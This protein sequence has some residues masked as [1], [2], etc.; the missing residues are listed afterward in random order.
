MP[1]NWSFNP[2]DVLGFVGG[3]INTYQT[4]KTNER[5]TRETNQVNREL[6]ELQNAAA[7]EESDKAYQRSKAT[8]QVNLLTGAGM[9]RAGAINTLNG[10]GSYTPAPV[11]TSQ[12]E[13]PQMQPIDFSALSNIMQISRAK[14]EEKHQKEMQEEQIKAQQE[15]LNKQLEDNQKQRESNERIAKLNADTTN[16]NADNRLNWEREQFDKLSPY[17]IRQIEANIS[18]VEADTEISQQNL[19]DLQYKYAEYVNT[20]STRDAI[21][22]FQELESTYNLHVTQHDFDDFRNSYMW[23]N[24][25]TG[26]WEYTKHTKTLRYIENKMSNFWDVIAKILPAD[27]LGGIIRK[28]LK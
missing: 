11:N 4:N 7:A 8:N 10:G 24:D 20:R 14:A 18:K 12:D 2:F 1:V 9:S 19:V 5:L 28:V 17:Q 25:D 21:S 26:E 27:K 3:A 15:A 16:R 22:L 13:S 23:F 6:V